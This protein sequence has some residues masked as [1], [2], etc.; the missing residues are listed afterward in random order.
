MFLQASHDVWERQQVLEQ[1][2]LSLK[3]T[4]VDVRGDGNCFYRAACYGLYGSESRHAE[5]R[6]LVADY[7]LQSGS[8][9]N[10]LVTVSGNSDV[11]AK[12]IDAL[13]SDGQSVGEEAVM[14]LANVCRREV[15]IYTAHVEPL[16][17]KPSNGAI[18]GAPVCLAFFEP[19]HYRAVTRMPASSPSLPSHCQLATET[20]NRL[21]PVDHPSFVAP[22]PIPGSVN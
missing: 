10:G 3:L 22:A 21:S 13:I 15:H 11:F 6:Q 7:V 20:E 19:G 5:L 18:S 16:V 4:T 17:Y 9:L 12:H 14:A 1:Y 8:I 2:L